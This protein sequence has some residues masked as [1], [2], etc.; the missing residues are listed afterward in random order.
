MTGRL[1]IILWLR[2]HSGG[3]PTSS[4]C[5]ESYDEH[6][7]DRPRRPARD[8][9]PHGP[10]RYPHRRANSIDRDDPMPGRSAAAWYRGPRTNSALL[11]A[12]RDQG[13]WWVDWSCWLA[14]QA[15]EKAA[16]PAAERAGKPRAAKVAGGFRLIQPRPDPLAPG[17]FWSSAHD[18]WNHCSLFHVGT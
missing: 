8:P 3:L 7:I 9:R 11:A 13:S 18:P 12:A 10:K 16:P 1:P 17:R 4:G 5:T 2:N 14:T 6:P 15:G